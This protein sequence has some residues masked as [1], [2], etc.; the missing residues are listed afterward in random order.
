[1]TPAEQ[2]LVCGHQRRL[3]NDRG[4]SDEAIGRVVVKTFELCGADCDFARKRQFGGT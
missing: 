2:S 1:M 3:V 4:R